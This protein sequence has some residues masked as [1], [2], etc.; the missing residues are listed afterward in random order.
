MRLFKPTYLDRE[1]KRQRTKKWYLDFNTADG[2]RHKLPL[3][4]DKRACE[5]VKN[6]IAE[7]ISCKVAGM[8]FEPE[9]QRKLDMLPARILKKL[10]TFGLLDNAR[11]EGSKP[12]TEHLTD[13]EKFLL[14]KGNTA[15]HC[16]QTKE[17]LLRVFEACKFRMFSDISAAK[18]LG[19]IADQ[20]T[21]GKISQRT[22]NFYIKA[23][24]QFGRWMVQ[25]RRAGESPLSVLTCET[26]TER[27]RQR[28]A[29]EPDDIRRLLEATK[30]AG[31]R[32]GMTGYQRALLYRLAVETG[33]RRA[34]LKSLK[35][36]SFDFENCTVTVEAGY[37]KNRRQSTIQLRKETS[38]IFANYLAGKLPTVQV[39]NVPDKTAK[40]LRADLAD[41]G[42]A[43]VD[44]AGRFADFHSLRHSTGSLLAASGAHPKVAQS[45]MR[46][47]D[48]N[49]TMSR[50]T[51]IFRG[52]ESKTVENLPDF[53]LSSS[54]AQRAIKTGTDDEKNVFDN[55]LDS[56]LHK[57]GVLGKTGLDCSGQKVCSNDE[58]TAFSNGRCGARTHDLL[59]KSQL[60]YQLS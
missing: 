37:S 2:I 33:L 44:D 38:A 17:T 31:E 16:R 60:L 36:S 21:S 11:V 27:K 15:R 3:F 34:E 14:A 40:M 7:C 43:Y 57:Q 6:T 22:A 30:A 55:C 29:L 46:H 25:H 32:F 18:F 1:G 5:G 42:I 45:L 51:H 54:Q 47:S 59:I 53:S 19:Y 28:R 52:Q 24:K 8:A 49:L 58:K 39:F 13:F 23:G 9:L 10:F 12:L 41:A 50:Y 4:A 20:K 35:V 26:I 48:I 56:S